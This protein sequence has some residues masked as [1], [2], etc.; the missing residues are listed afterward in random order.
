[1]SQTLI[2]WQ[3]W[4]SLP[5]LN[6]KFIKA[7]VDTGA[8]TSSIH[9][10]NIKEYSKNHQK[11]VRAFLTCKDAKYMQDTLLPIIFNP[12]KPDEFLRKSALLASH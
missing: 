11:F 5:D 12:H 10:Y 6:V 4:C 7:K 2:G 9:A 1:M 3:E 8:K